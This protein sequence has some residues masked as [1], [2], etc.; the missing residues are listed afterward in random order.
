MPINYDTP[1][2]DDIRKFINKK[3]EKGMLW[4]QILMAGKANDQEL[5]KFLE[6]R[7]EDDDWPS[8]TVDQWKELVNL[9]KQAIEETFIIDF[10]GGAA[11]IHNEDEDNA[12][13]IPD[14]NNSAWQTYKKGLLD[15]GFKPVSVGEIERASLRILKRLSLDTTKSR[16]IKG[17]V[18]G[19]VQSGKT[20]NMAALMAMAADWGWNMFIILSG[21]IDNLRKQTQSRLFGDLNR[22]NCK[23]VWRSLEHL[24]KNM[25]IGSR[26]Q[27][28]H[29]EDSS[30]D[31]YFTV[32][33]KNKKRLVNLIKWLQMSESTQSQMKILVI[34]DEADQ[35]GINTADI[36]SNEKKA[37]N[38]LI[39][40][41]V[42][43]NDYTDTKISVRYHAMN[44]IGYTATPYANILNDGRIDSLYPRNFIS[45]LAVSKEYFGPQQIFGSP[46]GIYEGLDIIR[47][48]NDDDI[49]LIQDL[50][51]NGGYILPLSLQNAICWFICGVACM[52]HLGY[53]KP[54][55]MLVHT[56][57]KTSHHSNVADAIELWITSNDTNYIVKKCHEVWDAETSRFTF[58][59]FRNQYPDYDRLDS[60]I[61]DYPDF[62][63]IDSEIYNLLFGQQRCSHIKLDEDK[64]LQYHTG[65]HLCVDNCTNNK[66]HGDS[67]V[68]LAY[69]D[70]DHMP[71][72][73]PAFIVVGGATLSRGLTLEGL[74]STYFLRT[75]GQ[76]DTLMQMGRWFGYRKNYELIPRVWLTER[77]RKQFEFLSEMDEL[78]REDIHTMEVMGKSPSE[79]GPKIMNTPTLSF[80]KITAKNR[81][82]SATAA[83]YQFAGTF[84]QTHIFDNDAEVLK[85]NMDCTLRFL[86]SLGDPSNSDR[87]LVW[88]GI[89][90]NQIKDYL[91]KYKFNSRLSVLNDISPLL[92]WVES[93]TN[94]GGLENWNVVLA[95]KEIKESNKTVY[96]SNGKSV[97]KIVRTRKKNLDDTTIINIGV[98]RDPRD[99][100]ADIDIDKASDEV[101][102]L[103]ENFE[104]KA[105]RAIRSKAGLDKTPQLIV[106]IID[107][108]SKSKR[109]GTQ[110]LNS[111][112]D[113][114]GICINIPEG[115]TRSNNNISSLTIKLPEEITDEKG[116]IDGTDED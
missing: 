82:Q 12:V 39:T 47:V 112:C 61:N 14:S 26:A 101:K 88:R 66:V 67:F 48:V 57:Q 69:P 5:K 29:F 106:Y 4:D 37:I 68:R 79:Y 42:N 40:A 86:D 76:A 84:K 45:T 83:E 93:I 1:I 113:I 63:S 114:A 38:K 3:F 36:D 11:T 19:N 81:M 17:L 91:L 110:D 102:I 6:S 27:D 34:D 60:E 92:E 8:I 28:L 56:S 109:H 108:D 35:A 77:T 30:S 100:I 90:M 99:L 2:Y 116:D 85:H 24:Q 62:S 65:I 80:I 70:K 23:L 51:D 98:L 21:T 13:H 50:H 16:P 73:A 9:Q 31:R 22:P 54:I 15:S 111:P 97:G 64:E 74:I 10:N 44:Y 49:Q 18:V 55:S 25:P 53:K 7:V 115:S 75:V 103:I 72:Q 96:L 104:S 89:H 41:L 107:K 105:A 20:A 87:A 52:R 78:L 46:T 59:D 95:G 71:D 94:N 32:C 43:G 58:E 33:L